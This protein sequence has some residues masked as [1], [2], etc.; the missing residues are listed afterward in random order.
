LCSVG[1]PRA[2]ERLAWAPDDRIELVYDVL[3]GGRVAELTL[4]FDFAGMRYS[5]STR[6]TSAG[7]LRWIW[8]WESVAQVRGR[9]TADRTQPEK[10]R[11][12]GNSR[13][14]PRTV[15]I[16]YVNGE[17]ARVAVEPSNRSDGREE[18]PVALRRGALDPASAIMSVLRQ[19][20]E[21]G[22]CEGRVPVFDGRQ[23]YDIVFKDAGT[24]K[25]ERE[26]TSIFAGE[27]QVCEFSWV[28]IAGRTRREGAPSRVEDDRR[29]G[30]AYLA[31]FDNGAA[32]APVRVEFEAWFGTVVGHLHAVRRT[33]TTADA[34]D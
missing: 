13:G 7:V 8:S 32:K 2:Q 3:A 10:Y 29:F 15:E 20:N 30:K 9:F 27:A 14:K 1:V 31:P 18:V 4:G 24:R 19:V 28:P 34:A 6:Q 12:V 16:D 33:H 21:T 22:T 26:G 11:V 17:P 25:L 5:I 23:R